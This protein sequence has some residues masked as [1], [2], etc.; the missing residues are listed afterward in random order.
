MAENRKTS[1]NGIAVI[2]RPIL[3]DNQYIYGVL[4]NVKEDQGLI[5]QELG[6]IVEYIDYIVGVE[7]FIKNGGTI[8]DDGRVWYLPDDVH[9]F[10][11]NASLKRIL[12][13]LMKG[14]VDV[15]KYEFDDYIEVKEGETDE[16]NTR[17]VLKK[18]LIERYV[19]EH[20]KEVEI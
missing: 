15:R 4:Y 10:L 20:N 13:H 12:T 2:S 11:N 1:Y 5:K 14:L 16:D 9:S 17:L 7:Q 19:N 8:S 6:D 18:D 3:V